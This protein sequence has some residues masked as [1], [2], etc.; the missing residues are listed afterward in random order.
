M[1]IILISYSDSDSNSDFDVRIIRPD[2]DFILILI[3]RNSNTLTRSNLFFHLI[4][5]YYIDNL[6][7]SLFAGK[8][9]NKIIN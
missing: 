2:Y 7:V 8:Y 4:S 1:I 5:L 6:A 9:E 3:C